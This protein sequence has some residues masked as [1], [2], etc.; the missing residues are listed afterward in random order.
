M[1]LNILQPGNKVTP[2]TI[3]TPVVSET[4]AASLEQKLSSSADKSEDKSIILHV[5]DDEVTSFVALRLQNEMQQFSIQNPTIVFMPG[6][7]TISGQIKLPSLNISGVG[8]VTAE[9]RITNGRL[10]I[11]LI[12]ATLGFLPVPPSM[13]QPLLNT[14]NEKLAEIQQGYTI[15]RVAISDGKMVIEMSR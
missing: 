2:M 13:I 4:A 14:A 1:P 5:T 3:R 12:K 9:P 6:K 8:L 15:E 7:V 10:E 11:V